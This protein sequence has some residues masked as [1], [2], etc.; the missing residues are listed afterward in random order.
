MQYDSIEIID[1][2]QVYINLTSIIIANILFSII[3]LSCCILTIFIYKKT[4]NLRT[5]IYRLFFNIALNELINRV[6]HL[7]QFSF[8]PLYYQIPENETSSFFYNICSIVIYFT[9]TNIIILLT[10]S[11]YSMYSLI[12]NENKKINVKY[13][14]Y[15]RIIFIISAFFTLIYSIFIILKSA[16]S[17][18]LNNVI[19][20]NFVNNFIKVETS[21]LSNLHLII[22]LSIYFVLVTY[23]FAIIIFINYFIAQKSKCT[24]DDADL[25]EQKKLEK[26]QKL[27]KLK[28]FTNKMYNYPL[29]EIIWYIPFF[30]YSL[31]EFQRD[32]NDINYSIIKVKFI[33]YI[34]NNFVDS[35]RGILCFKIFISNEKIMILFKN[36]FLRSSIFKTIMDL[37]DENKSSFI[38]SK[39]TSISM[40]CY[41]SEDNPVLTES[42]AFTSNVNESFKGNSDTSSNNINEEKNAIEEVDNEQSYIEI[43]DRTYNTNSEN[44]NNDNIIPTI[45]DNV[46]KK[47]DEES[48]VNRKK[49]FL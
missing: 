20:I 48:V 22:T 28:S 11:C 41:S 38:Q 25:N 5:I 7:I 27:F 15:M 8:S 29:L 14:I 21:I 10:F 30:S 6:F 13:K 39:N 26:K 40:S 35:I 33:I 47:E 37:M 3:S 32:D 49:H 2:L 46:G 44:E 42:K 12:L 17:D 9:N 31:F 36:K 4:N 24:E 19:S 43:S 18:I 1:K 34:I 16:N 45:N 23:A